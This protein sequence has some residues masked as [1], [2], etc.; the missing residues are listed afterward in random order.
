[1]SRNK[2]PATKLLVRANHEPNPDRKARE[3]PQ[4]RPNRCHTRHNSP[5]STHQAAP[6]PP[7]LHET[8]GLNHRRDTRR[9]H[10]HGLAAGDLRSE[11][12]I[13][14]SKLRWSSPGRREKRNEGEKNIWNT[15]DRKRGGEKRESGDR[16]RQSGRRK[17]K[18]ARLR[19]GWRRE[20]EE[21]GEREKGP[22]ERASFL[23]KN[24]RG[25]LFIVTGPTPK[26]TCTEIL[27]AYPRNLS[28][29]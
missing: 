17:S 3:T 27:N 18:E 6:K 28:R 9:P 23:L 4:R 8:K 26:G 14:G 7:E 12:Q 22:Q 2:K 5:E 16:E 25:L 20:R 15:H 29:P 13:S 1:M 21:R 24:C 11:T 19:E 10:A